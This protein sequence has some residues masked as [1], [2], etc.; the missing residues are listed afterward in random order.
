M[1]GDGHL[2]QN[3]FQQVWKGRTQQEGV[4]LIDF[5]TST[6]ETKKELNQNYQ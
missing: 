1:Q 2:H 5:H 3:V 4:L 6:E